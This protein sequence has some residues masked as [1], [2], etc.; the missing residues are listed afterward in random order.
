MASLY[1]ELF[2]D[3]NG[4]K[5]RRYTV[6]R[7]GWEGFAPLDKLSNIFSVCAAAALNP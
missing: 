1:D 4:R 6:R 2:E 3:A 7:F 5:P